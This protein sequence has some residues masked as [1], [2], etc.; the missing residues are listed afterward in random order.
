MFHCY[1]DKI[2]N[3]YRFWE[4]IYR[5]IQRLTEK[6]P[7][8]IILIILRNTSLSE[9]ISSKNNQSLQILAKM[10]A[11]PLPNTGYDR[12]KSMGVEVPCILSLIC[13]SPPCVFSTQAR[14]LSSILFLI[15]EFFQIFKPFSIKFY[16]ICGP[17][18]YLRIWLD[19]VC[20]RLKSN[21]IIII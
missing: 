18:L 3:Y 19:Q 12:R 13:L 7:I 4:N 9:L 16:F 11:L 21:R 1:S 2:C 6:D 20:F 10:C 15:Q 14:D 17:K 5:T 8:N